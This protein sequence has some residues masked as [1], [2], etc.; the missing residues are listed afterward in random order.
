MLFTANRIGEGKFFGEQEIIDKG[1][2]AYS[3]NICSAERGSE[4][5]MVSRGDILKL[6]SEAELGK[7]R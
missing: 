4:L 5:M 6:F 1:K 3:V 7:I 2:P